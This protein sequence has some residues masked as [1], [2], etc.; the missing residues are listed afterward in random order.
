M[1]AYGAPGKGNTL[2]NY[3]GIREDFVELRGRPQPAQ[4]RSLHPGHA[5]PDPPAGDAHGAQARLRA[6]PAVESEDE[7]VEQIA[8]IRDWGGRFVVPIPE[9]QEYA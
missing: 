8:Y 4:A 1:A 6:D 9:V 5:H 2:L 3:C 7:I